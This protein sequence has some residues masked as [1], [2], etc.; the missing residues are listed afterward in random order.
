MPF[1][2]AHPAIILPFLRIRPERISAT[3]LV[4]GSTA[5]DFEYFFKMSVNSYYSH[6]VLSILY[7]NIPITLALAFLFHEVVKRNLI[8]NLPA[9]FQY[10][11]QTL[12]ELD[13]VAHFK[14]HYWVVIISAGI[15]SFS[16]IFWDAFTHNDGFFAQR[17]SLYK[18]VVIPFDGV[19][20]PLFYGLQYI[21]TFVGLAIVILF[22]IFLKP[23]K[24][25]PVSNPQIV[26]W[27][28]II[29]ITAVV[30]FL[31][32]FFNREDLTEGNF[33]VSAVSAILIAT[34]TGGFIK[35]NKRTIT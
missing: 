14:R 29:F 3:A 9:F 12:L 2:P 16:H 17:I 24:I 6:T 1:T 5:P 8:I 34:F 23:N 26:Y 4:I 22:I 11:F 21:S 20:Y 25:I 13:F 10:R 32:F 19:R 15:G 28:V 30:L 27:L 35:F 33:V 7:F 18:H 31:R